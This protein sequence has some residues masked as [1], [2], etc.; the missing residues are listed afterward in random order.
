MLSIFASIACCCSCLKNQTSNWRSSRDQV[1]T[2]FQC[3][4]HRSRKFQLSIPLETPCWC[5][6]CPLDSAV[7]MILVE[8]CLLRWP[9]PIEHHGKNRTIIRLHLSHQRNLYFRCIEKFSA[10]KLHNDIGKHISDK[11]TSSTNFL[12]RRKYPCSRSFHHKLFRAR[13]IR[14]NDNGACRF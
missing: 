11:M 7:Y 3:I 6:E 4:L 13:C 2:W 9:P 12:L 1:C 10:S 5:N 8:C 14:Q